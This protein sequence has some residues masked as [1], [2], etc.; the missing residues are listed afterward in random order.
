MSVQYYK[1][2]YN[3]VFDTSFDFEA[4]PDP[5]EGAFDRLVALHLCWNRSICNLIWS[6]DVR[7]ALWECY[8]FFPHFAAPELLTEQEFRKFVYYAVSHHLKYLPI[9]YLPKQYRNDPGKW[10]E[11]QLQHGESGS[12]TEEYVEQDKTES[13][14]KRPR[15]PLVRQGETIETKR[16]TEEHILHPSVGLSDLDMNVR[17]VVA[18]FLD[19]KDW[20]ALRTS[21]RDAQDWPVPHVDYDFVYFAIDNC[22]DIVWQGVA[23]TLTDV[24]YAL[25]AL[26]QAKSNELWAKSGDMKLHVRFI[27]FDRAKHAIAPLML[28]KD[29]QYHAD[30]EV[31]AIHE[32]GRHYCGVKYAVPLSESQRTLGFGGRKSENPCDDPI[33]ESETETQFRD[34]FARY[35]GLKP[36]EYMN[37]EHIGTRELCCSFCGQNVDSCGCHVQ[38][39]DKKHG[40]GG[41]DEHECVIFYSTRCFNDGENGLLVNGADDENEVKSWIIFEETI[42]Q[43][44]H[45][46]Y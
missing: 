30:T 12:A 25:N 7:E 31:A 21:C 38:P 26:H 35:G 1:K 22:V 11:L 33:L 46:H 20:M 15:L 42:R 4:A 34:F 3:Y 41:E 29:Y 9:N 10:E 5:P 16:N 17:N 24:R 2:K 19:S 28:F 23:H 8:K 27:M 43:W 14:F 37:L 36:K 40:P 45:D 18:K 6:R 39:D 13:A 44:D 32:L